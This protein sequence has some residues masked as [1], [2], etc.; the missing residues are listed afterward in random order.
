MGTGRPHSVR[1]VLAACARA[2]GRPVPHTD[3]A[4]RPGD[5]PIAVADPSRFFVEHGFEATI[6]LDL[7]VASALRWCLDNPD[8]YGPQPLWGLGTGGALTA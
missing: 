6:G 2:A 1:E 7:M 3:G 5:L 4:R 8:G